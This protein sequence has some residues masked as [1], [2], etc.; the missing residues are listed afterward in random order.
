[1][2]ISL[3]TPKRLKEKRKKKKKILSIRENKPNSHSAEKCK[4]V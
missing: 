4:Q 2:A 1:M 3:Y